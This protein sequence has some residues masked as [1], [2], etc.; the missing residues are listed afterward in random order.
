MAAARKLEGGA[1]ESGAL[2]GIKRLRGPLAR[3]I[4]L[5]QF[6]LLQELG[7]GAFG[8]VRKG[9]GS[10]SIRGFT[11]E[12]LLCITRDNHWD[13]YGKVDVAAEY[14]YSK[15]LWGN[16]HWNFDEIRWKGMVRAEFVGKSPFLMFII[17]VVAN[18]SSAYH[19]EFEKTLLHRLQC[20]T[21]SLMLEKTSII[22]ITNQSD[23]PRGLRKAHL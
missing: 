5:N 17:W 8:I 15:I 21:G 9:E 12:A 11:K 2:D 19:R 23:F 4:R 20:V 18:L 3:T 14:N 16:R 6:S 7:R 10:Y 1:S 22:K 13:G